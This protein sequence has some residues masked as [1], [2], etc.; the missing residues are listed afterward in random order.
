MQT[1]ATP[2]SSVGF[3]A[4]SRSSD[5]NCPF[6]QGEKNY[7]VHI[8]RRTKILENLKVITLYSAVTR[9]ELGNKTC[10][11]TRSIQAKKDKRMYV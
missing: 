4:S 6:S 5:H 11:L 9:P 8:H 7:F 10:M 3:V 1:H 2:Y